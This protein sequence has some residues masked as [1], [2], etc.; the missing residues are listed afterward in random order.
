MQDNVNTLFAIIAFAIGFPIFWMG[1]VYLVSRLSGWSSL[2]KRYPATRP[3]SGQYFGWSSGRISRFSNYNHSINVTISSTGVHLETV[4]F[5]KF[6]HAPVFLPWDAIVAMRH[7]KILFRH[8]NRAATG[9]RRLAGDHPALRRKA[10]GCLGQGRSGA[11]GQAGLTSS[12]S[13]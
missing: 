10:G 2:A 5:F 9:R 8:L 3:A 7:S 13:R 4:F 6:G 12:R 11:A 1:V